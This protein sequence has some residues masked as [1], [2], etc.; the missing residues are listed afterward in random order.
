MKTLFK[1]VLILFTIAFSESAL[2]QQITVKASID[3][4]LIL[5]GKQSH[6]LFE[7][8]QPKGVKVQFPL[9]TDTLVTGVNILG[10]SKPDTIDLGH[11]RIQIKQML[12]ITSFDS[13]LYYIPPY[14][15]VAGKD[16]FNSNA[17]SFKTITYNVDTTKQTI[18]DIKKVYDP[19]FDWA[20]F[21]KVMGIIALILIVLL[22]AAFVVW[23]YILKKP[24]PFISKET[25]ILTPYQ[26]ALNELDEISKAKLWQHGRDKEYYTRLT[27][28]IRK[29]MEKRF[30]IG[31]I[32]MTSSEIMEE[33]KII[34]N[35]YSA[36][37]DSLRKLLQISDLV[38]FAKWHPLSEENELSLNI[39]YLFV[40]QTKIE[41]ETQPAV[42]S[43]DEGD[44]HITVPPAQPDPTQR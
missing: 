5:I 19:P 42:E 31:A 9:F 41:E 34:Q 25:I 44:P 43:D 40:N 7:V 8:A 26:Q 32:E 29:Y 15:F 11:D 22:A 14:P 2:A 10:K 33:A 38:K 28:V 23:K 21:F 16:T 24:L 3:S 13:A 12:T 20:W 39:C 36:A 35:E 27:D 18:F 30:N 1:T 4:S 17:L 6:L 37:Y